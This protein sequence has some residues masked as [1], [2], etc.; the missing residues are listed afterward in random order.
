ML[1][2]ETIKKPPRATAYL[3]DEQ[4]AMARQGFITVRAAADLAHVRVDR[5]YRAIKNQ[6]VKVKLGE[7]AY[8]RYV[9]KADWLKFMEKQ[10]ERVLHSLGLEGEP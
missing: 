1:K 5:V 10:R 3:A 9:H 2:R 7:N 6:K 4:A 8:T